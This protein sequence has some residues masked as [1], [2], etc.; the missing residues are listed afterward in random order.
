MAGCQRKGDWEIENFPVE[1]QA[2][3][4]VNPIDAT[5]IPGY[6]VCFEGMTIGVKH[7]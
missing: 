2:V 1:Q 5:H 3:P 7:K 6:V 4:G